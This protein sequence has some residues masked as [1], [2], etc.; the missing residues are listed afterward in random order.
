[1]QQ[2]SCFDSIGQELTLGGGGGVASDPAV[3]VAVEAV[4]DVGGDVEIDAELRA[5]VAR[6][7][8]G[9]ALGAG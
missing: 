3:Q 4:V 5:K 2:T 7:E 8:G 9:R 1:M 6:G